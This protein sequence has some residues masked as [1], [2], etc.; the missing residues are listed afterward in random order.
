[1][2]AVHVPYW[3]F[4]QT[5]ALGGR[6]QPGPVWRSSELV[7]V[8]GEHRGNYSGVLIGASGV[9]TPS[10]TASLWPFELSTGVPPTGRPEQRGL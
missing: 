7:S 10:E 8:S 9:L 2:T 4:G 1:M 3:V 5:F 6:H